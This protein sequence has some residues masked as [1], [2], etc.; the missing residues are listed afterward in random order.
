TAKQ[1]KDHCA[2][3]P[4]ARVAD[5]V[6]DPCSLLI[7]RDLLIKPRRYTQLQESL[8]GIS[9]RT[10]ANKLKRLQREGLIIRRAM[11]GKRSLSEYT[12]SKKGRAF[13]TVDRAMRRYGKK[14]L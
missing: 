14:Y 8:T 3:C 4:V 5:L 13:Q 12:L 1:Q 9:S 11:R 7:M 6:G 2:D 10:L